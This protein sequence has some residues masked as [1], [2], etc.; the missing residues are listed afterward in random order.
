MILFES[1][2]FYAKK[3][4]WRLTNMQLVGVICI[5]SAK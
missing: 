5:N 3:R 2:E 1:L 4:L